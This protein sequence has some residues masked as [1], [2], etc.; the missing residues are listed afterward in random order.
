MKLRD[1]KD[2]I[3]RL[4]ARSQK[5]LETCDLR[6][7][8]IVR[9]LSMVMD[10]TVIEGHRSVARQDALFKAG[11]SKVK[12]GGSK[13]NPKPSRAVDICPADAPKLWALHRDLPRARYNAMYAEAKKIADAAGI[14]T[15]WGGDWDG[16][17]DF[18]DQN[19]N[20]LVHIELL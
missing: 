10:I 19:F 20:D 5:R 14:K 9:E 8:Y 7:Q 11:A 13:H 15:R 18:T 12:G 1:Y 16:D 17:G 4:S 2:L 6:L 3:F